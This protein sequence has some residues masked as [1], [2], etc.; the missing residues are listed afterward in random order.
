MTR[1]R[2]YELRSA[3]IMSLQNLI[4]EC[5]GKVS[6]RVFMKLNKELSRLRREY[7]EI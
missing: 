6:S 1:L 5:A 2:Q 4:S 3:K 7:F